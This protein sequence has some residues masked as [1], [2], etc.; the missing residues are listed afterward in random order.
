MI[1]E[2]A[3]ELGEFYPKKL[4]KFPEFRKFSKHAQLQLIKKAMENHH[5]QLITHYAEV[6]NLLDASRK[7]EVQKALN[8]IFKKIQDFEEEREKILLEFS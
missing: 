7:P 5:K 3:I 1:L 6:N 4:K 2:E 8:R